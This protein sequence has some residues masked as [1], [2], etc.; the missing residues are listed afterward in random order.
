[1]SAAAA[2]TKLMTVAEF[3]VWRGDGT[4]RR[5]ELVDGV[6]RM[7]DAAS[8]AHGT[9]QSNLN[10]R[11]GNHLLKKRPHCH[12]VANPGVAPRTRT[13]WNYRE[14]ELGVTCAPNRADVHMVPRPVLLIEVL[15]PSNYKQTWENVALYQDLASVMEILVVEATKVGVHVLRRDA[16]GQW[17]ATPEVLGAGAGIRLAGSP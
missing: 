16:D 11:I 8:H 4:G 9:I 5:Y 2:K 6:P 15:S 3:L 13:E 17:P 1:M 14:P 7:Q 10:I 12:M